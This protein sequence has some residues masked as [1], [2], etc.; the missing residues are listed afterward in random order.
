MVEPIRPQNSRERVTRGASAVGPGMTRP[1]L[2]FSGRLIALEGHTE[3]IIGRADRLCD[4]VIPDARISRR[5]A[6]IML[7][8][9]RYMIR[10]LGSMNGTFVNGERASGSY[11]LVP[12]DEITLPPHKMLFVLAGVESATTAEKI[13]GVSQVI[14][15]K[16]HF[17]GLL[18]ALGVADLVQLLNSTLQSGVLTV[19]DVSQHAGK[20]TLI[21]GE[22]VEAEFGEQK[23]EEAVYALLA[24]TEGDFEFAQGTPSQPKNPIT[25]KT[26]CLLLEGL[27]L[28]DE[29]R[30]KTQS[31]PTTYS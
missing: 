16:G 23:R 25:E 11:G 18:H 27:R 19:K 7:R 12:G 13:V 3:F 29:K 5:H 20:L 10:D 14:Q 6:A 9:G 4:L 21:Q 31:I 22:V 17:S 26:V 2:L 30:S 28:F 24:L 8:G 1:C 15:P